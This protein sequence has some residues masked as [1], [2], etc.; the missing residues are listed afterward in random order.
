M[1]SKDTEEFDLIKFSKG[2]AEVWTYFKVKQHKLSKQIIDNVAVC[3]KCGVEVKCPGGTSNLTSHVRRHHP[4][5]LCKSQPGTESVK[6][7]PEVKKSDGN[8]I[9]FFGK[10][11]GNNTERAKIITEK[12]ARFLIKD[13]RPYCMVDSKGFRELLLCM[14]SRY[15][16]PSR[17][18]FSDV[19]VPKMYLDVK[20][21]TVK[22]SILQAEQ[23]H[24]R[25]CLLNYFEY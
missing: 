16:V 18:T 5:L 2:K 20:E 10:K 11:Y 6:Q 14:D 12:I 23:V 1:A 15:Q 22:S 17:K 21:E 7:T 13:L 9:S 19:I 4:Q 25:Y 3:V 8:L 24:L